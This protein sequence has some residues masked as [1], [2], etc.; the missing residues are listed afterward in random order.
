VPET[1]RSLSPIVS[2]PFGEEF[3]G[4]RNAFGGMGLVVSSLRFAPLAAIQN[5]RLAPCK[6][7][8]YPPG[9]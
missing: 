3:K 7:L 9:S 2:R 1:F 4:F 8:H 5:A 6:V